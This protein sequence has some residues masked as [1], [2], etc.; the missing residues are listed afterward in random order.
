MEVGLKASS[1]MCMVELSQWVEKQ[2]GRPLTGLAPGGDVFLSD[3]HLSVAFLLILTVVM[4][5]SGWILT[6]GYPYEH[7]KR[8]AVTKGAL[9]RDFTIPCPKSSCCAAQ[10]V[11]ML[12]WPI[13]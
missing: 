6:T 9:Q 13:R 11:M 10:S 8:T 7:K 2:M 3:E 12:A 1:C 5:I 4:H